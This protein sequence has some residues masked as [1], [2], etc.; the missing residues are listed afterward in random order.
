M[1]KYKIKIPIA[2]MLLLST[3]GCKKFVENGNV[4]I[5]PNAASS[6][7]LKSTLPALID[8]TAT[9]TYNVAYAT[10]L[11]AQQMSAYS[12]GP[13]SIDR[14]VDV[15][16][17]A[18]E[19]LYQA[20][21]TNAKI[22]IDMAKAQ[23]A[24]YYAA[25]GRILMV[26]NLLMATDLYGD[27]PYSDA[28]KAPEVLYPIYD[29]QQDLYATMQTLLD[30][31]ITDAKATS[32][33]AVIPATDDLAYKG[34]MAR[35]VETAYLLKARL[36]M[37]TTKKG[38]TAAANSALTALATAYT[39]NTGDYQ[40]VYNSR[41]KNPWTVNIALRITTGNFFIA[42]SRRFT[43]AMN[44][45]IY[46]GLVDPRLPLMMDK[47]TSPL[48]AGLANGGGN[49]G[50]TV[51]LTI[52]TF[53]GKELSALVMASYAEQ[54][55]M[56]AEARFLANGGSA[57]STGTTQAAYDAYI[58]GITA[59]MTKI[60]VAPADRTTYLANPL[61]AVGPAGLKMEHIMKEKQIALYL[62]PEAW[63]DVR[64]YDYNPA[65]FA[66]MALPLQ[67]WVD[68]GG[69]YI[70]RS[71]IPNSELSRNPNSKTLGSIKT[72]EKVWWDQ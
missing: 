1:L 44:G 12:A 54:K 15:R 64:R 31:A 55:L 20:G 17:D 51:D 4:N 69:Q 50:N 2:F 29:K 40:V 43:D 27:V 21:M 10:T 14:N 9:N 5:N 47:R 56:E 35:W 8:A 19:G 67:Q 59:H 58:A 48:Y 62:N 39:A 70:R 41:N 53:Y 65:I 34:V 37:H 60:G 30:E 25:I 46:T 52:S 22:L 45:N 72:T 26:Q 57:S 42:P 3:A 71:G 49:T 68:M 28:F 63:V 18:M 32:G 7:T 24:P 16:V 6:T 36:Y 23:N 33:G 61:V 13:I 38:A 11:F 66:S